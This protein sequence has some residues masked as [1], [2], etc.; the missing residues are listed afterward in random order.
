M[1]NTF[2]WLI[3]PYTASNVNTRLLYTID[4]RIKLLLKQ[5]FNIKEFNDVH[6]IILLR[7][8]FTKRLFQISSNLPRVMVMRHDKFIELTENRIASIYSITVDYLQ[9]RDTDATVVV[10]MNVQIRCL[11][12]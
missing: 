7:E 1:A 3:Q 11:V 8:K 4:K 10:Q 5:F 6:L 9:T 2:I 12:K